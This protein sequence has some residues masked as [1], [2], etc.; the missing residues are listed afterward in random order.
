MDSKPTGMAGISDTGLGRVVSTS[1]KKLIQLIIFFAA[2]KSE[3]IKSPWE[4]NKYILDNV[5]I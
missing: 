3:A 4:K 1:L 5:T 2:C